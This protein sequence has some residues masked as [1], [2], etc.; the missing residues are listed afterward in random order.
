MGVSKHRSS[1]LVVASNLALTVTLVSP[2]VACR[3][4]NKAPAPAP[5][6]ESV[7]VSERRLSKVSSLD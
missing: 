4:N 3:L 1:W 5:V 7:R 6:D 2:M